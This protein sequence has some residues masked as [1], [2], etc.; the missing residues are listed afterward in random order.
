[1]AKVAIICGHCGNVT[2]RNPCQVR[3]HTLMFCN[4]DCRF[5]HIRGQREARVRHR[6]QTE[7]IKDGDCWIWQGASSPKGY[8]GIHSGRF[9]SAHRSAYELFVGPIPLGKYVIHTCDRPACINPAHLRVATP[10]QNTDDMIAK[11]R[12][13]FWGHGRDFYKRYGRKP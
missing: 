8:G 2:H 11:D 5:E 12:H 9:H 13:S 10:Q 4:R 7:Y 1:M 3:P 6:L